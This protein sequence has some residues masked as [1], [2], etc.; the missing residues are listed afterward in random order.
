MYIFQ[1]G[2]EGGAENF[3][4]KGSNYLVLSRRTRGKCVDYDGV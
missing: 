4:K 1:E 3:E 2:P